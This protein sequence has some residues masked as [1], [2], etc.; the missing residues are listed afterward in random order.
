MLWKS[1]VVNK[2][3]G[4][5]LVERGIITNDQL[6]QAL[7]IQSQQDS[8][9]RKLLGEILATLGYA[10]EEDVLTSV[11]AQYGI[12]YLPLE[13][14]EIDKE[15]IKLV[16]ASLV[17]QHLFIPIDR[18]ESLLTIVIADV[19]DAGAIAK[20][21][22]SLKCKVAVFVSSSSSLRAAIKKHYG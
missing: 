17:R 4:E 3:L 12:P 20:I 6:K 9:Q 18:R 19:P 5:M 22:E 16:P 7:A 2:R 14:Y 15:L 11:T 8:G 13:S 10:S 1:R 21:E